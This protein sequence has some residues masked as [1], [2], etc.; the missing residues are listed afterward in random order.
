MKKVVLS[1]GIKV[2]LEPDSTSFYI[3]WDRHAL[4]ELV[5]KKSGGK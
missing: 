2:K 1:L 3:N 4:L 5:Y